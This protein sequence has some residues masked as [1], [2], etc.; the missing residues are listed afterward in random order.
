LSYGVHV[1][2]RTAAQK[3]PSRDGSFAS[4]HSFLKRASAMNW[5]LEPAKDR[6]ETWL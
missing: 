5:T 4:M 6:L 3:A 2:P 1:T